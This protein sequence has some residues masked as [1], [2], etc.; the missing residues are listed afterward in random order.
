MLWTNK[1]QS[2]KNYEKCDADFLHRCQAKEAEQAEKRRKKE[3]KKISKK[4]G[5]KN[6]T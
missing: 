1:S 4:I 5:L 6:K 2:K 3:E